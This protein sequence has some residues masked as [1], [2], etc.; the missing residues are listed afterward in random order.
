MRF[1]GSQ[2][3]LKQS[4]VAVNPTSGCFIGLRALVF[5]D[6]VVANGGNCLVIPQIVAYVGEAVEYDKDRATAGNGQQTIEH[7]GH[8][9]GSV[10]KGSFLCREKTSA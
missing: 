3:I 2:D 10:S 6:V 9:R 8:S 5:G 1:S 4:N 7:G